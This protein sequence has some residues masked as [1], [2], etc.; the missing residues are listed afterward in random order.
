[1]DFNNSFRFSGP[2]VCGLMRKH[3][4]TIKRLASAMQ[5]PQW[6]I[7]RV[8]AQGIAGH[9]A[10]DWFQAI[11]GSLSPRMQAAYLQSAQA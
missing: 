5:I 3:R 10:C 1:M 7:R 2:E 8:R 4:V 11:T 9:A 6:R